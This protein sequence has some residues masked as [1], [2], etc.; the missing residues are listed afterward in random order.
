MI[1]YTPVPM[2]TIF[3]GTT[4]DVPTMS[5]VSFK[6]RTVMAYNRGDGRYELTRL[7]TTEPKD[8]LD[9]ELQPGRE[10]FPD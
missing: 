2:E 3:Q 7:L 9:P 6:G 5:I 1:L 8:Y 10:I 4:P